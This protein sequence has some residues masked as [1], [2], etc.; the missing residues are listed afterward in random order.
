MFWI[1][2][3]GAIFEAFAKFTNW[4]LLNWWAGQL[5]HKYWEGFNFEDLIFPMF[6]FIA[7]VSIPFSINKRLQLGQSKAQIYKHALVIYSLI[8]LGLLEN[9]EYSLIWKI[10]FISCINALG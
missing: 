1:I 2:G 3:G 5:Q 6:L 4:P 10:T 9:E 7:G 8:V